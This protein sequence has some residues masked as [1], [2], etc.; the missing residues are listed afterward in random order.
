M[1][2]KMQ[3]WLTQAHKNGLTHI[4][5]E[6]QLRSQGWKEIDIVKIMSEKINLTLSDKTE[7]QQSDRHTLKVILS[8]IAGMIF[9]ALVAFGLYVFHVY[10]G[11]LLGSE[12]TRYKNAIVEWMCMTSTTNPDR[13][14]ILARLAKDIGIPRDQL[15]SS[16]D[17]TVNQQIGEWW[18][19]EIARV[20]KKYGF[21]SADELYGFSSVTASQSELNTQVSALAEKRCK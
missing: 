3:D 21:E 10:P 20:A 1:E 12:E 5:I 2:E 11:T 18:N 17:E 13:E 7:K 8:A 9:A 6:G 4:E 15:F 19:S 16:P 14:K